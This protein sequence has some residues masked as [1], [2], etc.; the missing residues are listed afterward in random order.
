MARRRRVRHSFPPS[1]FLVSSLA[2]GERKKD[3]R[4]K[5]GRVVE[6]EGR[7]DGCRAGKAKKR[8]IEWEEVLRADGKEDAVFPRRGEEKEIKKESGEGGRGQERSRKSKSE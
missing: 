6:G 7:S 5:V 1:F 4:G 2:V 3:E 8:K